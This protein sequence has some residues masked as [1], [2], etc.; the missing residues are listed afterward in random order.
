MER[1]IHYIWK[2]R[3]FPQG[4]LFTT[5]G[6]AFTIIDPGIH[7][8][9]AGPDFFNAKIRIGNQIWAGNVEIHTMASDWYKHGHHKDEAYNSVILHLVENNDWEGTITQSGRIIPQYI[10]HIPDKIREN[11]NY[12]FHAEREIPCLERISE[13][14]EIYLTDWKNA[15]TA[16]RM[17]YKNRQITDILRQNKGDWEDAFYILLSRSFG[18]GINSDV[19]ER[20]AKSLPL[21][22]IQKHQDNIL[23]VEALLFGQAGLLEDNEIPCEYYQCLRKEFGFLRKKFDIQPLDGFLFKKLRIRPHNFPHVKIAQ[24]AAILCQNDLFFS[25]ILAVK[26]TREYFRFF[27]PDT[28]EY[29]LTH[30]HFKSSSGRKEKKLGLDALHILLI[31]TVVPILFAYGKKKKQPGLTEYSLHLLESIPE[32]K[33]S[34]VS[35]FQKAGVPVKNAADSQALIQLKRNYC[36][37]KE[38]LFC[39][40]GHKLLAKPAGNHKNSSNFVG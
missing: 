21:K 18:F 34:I 7:N 10:I 28:S 23:Q 14:S 33:N 13:I 4:T 37:R 6:E 22:Y 20:L 15:L 38:C 1:L 26:D 24:L 35:L 30:Y 40:I 36:E 11:Y 17:E 12:L 19:F 16:E 2:H 8:T 25:K 32:E 29:W 3:F 39:R 27:T 9:H 5:A 31:N